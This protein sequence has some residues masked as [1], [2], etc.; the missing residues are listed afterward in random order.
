MNFL[1]TSSCSNISTSAS[2]HVWSLKALRFGSMALGVHSHNHD[3][4]RG[5]RLSPVMADIIYIIYQYEFNYR[6]WMFETWNH[7]KKSL[8]WVFFLYIVVLLFKR[9]DL[10]KDNEI[11]SRFGA[12]HRGPSFALGQSTCNTEGLHCGLE[13]HWNILKRLE[14][15]WKPVE[16]CCSLTNKI[17]FRF[18]D[19]IGFHCFFWFKARAHPGETCASWVMRGVGSLGV[20]RKS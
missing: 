5:G 3:G 17:Y 8:K 20:P 7:R 18:W 10:S 16:T 14:I 15:C 2:S 13:A 9:N 11:F 6:C 19:F 1:W 12:L 4:Q